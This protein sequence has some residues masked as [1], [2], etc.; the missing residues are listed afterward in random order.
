[1]LENPD[2]LN[3]QLQLAID[4]LKAEKENIIMQER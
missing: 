2:E 3:K 1:M 4:P